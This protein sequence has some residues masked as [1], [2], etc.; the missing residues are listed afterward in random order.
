MIACVSAI[1]AAGDLHGIDM[2]DSTPEQKPALGA[3]PEAKRWAAWQK[4]VA[5]LAA[6]DR[7]QAEKARAERQR[8]AEQQ[9]HDPVAFWVGVIV[10]IVLLVVGL[11]IVDVMR[12]DP[13]MSDNIHRHACP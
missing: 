10:P 3:S 1:N 6:E 13:R 8:E 11:F 4:D 9:Y 12:C 7:E 5:T 2:T